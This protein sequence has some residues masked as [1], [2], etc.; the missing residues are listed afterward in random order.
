[1]SEPTKHGIKALRNAPSFWLCKGSEPLVLA[2]DGTPAG[3][4]PLVA[5]CKATIEIR[6]DQPEWKEAY[7]RWQSGKNPTDDPRWKLGV[8]LCDI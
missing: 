3:W 1:M 4:F 8:F 5:A 6:E 7:A 2:S